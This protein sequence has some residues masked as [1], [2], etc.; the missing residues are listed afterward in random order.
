MPSWSRSAVNEFSRSLEGGD[1]H[2]LGG[3]ER[4]EI[5]L[6]HTLVAGHKGIRTLQVRRIA[7]ALRELCLAAR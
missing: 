5:V 3:R 2:A 6:W 4:D 7:A 1:S